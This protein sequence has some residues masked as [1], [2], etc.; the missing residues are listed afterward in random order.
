MI[1]N[2][3]HGNILKVLFFFLQFSFYE[4]KIGYIKRLIYVF[5]S[6]Y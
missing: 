2:G 4:M 5:D 6:F 3:F 1:F